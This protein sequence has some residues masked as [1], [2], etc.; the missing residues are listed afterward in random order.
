MKTAV[1]LHGMPSK[2]EYYNSESEA[3]S[4]KHW[5]PWIQRRLILKDILAQTPEMPRP[6]EPVYEEWKRVFEQFP[7]NEETILIGH[8][9]GGGFLVRW[10][11][12]NR[13]RVGKIVLVA[14]W[15]DPKPRELSTGFFE[16]DIDPNLPSRAAS[17][18]IFSSDNEKFEPVRK[19]VEILTATW[20]DAKSIEL[21]GKGHFTL[22]G[23]KTSEFPELE[24][25]VL[26]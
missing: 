8:S 4:N 26:N 14:P 9:C 17:L 23:M 3:Q 5:L 25:E 1:I 21:S 6:F 16:F 12:E 11:S 13:V 10:L 19:S 22:N 18:T 2:E 7:I 15:I 20:P 24:A